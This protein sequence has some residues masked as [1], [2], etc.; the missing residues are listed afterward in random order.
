MLFVC[1]N[2]TSFLALLKRDL[3]L[4]KKQEDLNMQSKAK[5]YYVQRIFP[6]EEYSAHDSHSL[7]CFI[8]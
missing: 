1:F 4:R 6:P 2:M 7:G 3:P 5:I 8:F